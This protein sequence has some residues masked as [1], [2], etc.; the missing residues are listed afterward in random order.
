MKYTADL[1]Y[2]FNFCEIPG[3]NTAARS[4]RTGT[5]ASGRYTHCPPGSLKR[6]G[7]G[8]LGTHAWSSSAGSGRSRQRGGRGVGELG[9]QCDLSSM[10]RAPGTFPGCLRLLPEVK[11]PPPLLPRGPGW[12]SG[13]VGPGLSAGVSSRAAGESERETRARFRG[14]RVENGRPRVRGSRSEEARGAFL[15]QTRVLSNL[16]P[17]LEA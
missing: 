16:S 6:K 11:L 13:R 1:S 10:V 14:V 9:N 3:S 12:G 5:P 4:T 7:R 15:T 17:G 8:R 2:Y